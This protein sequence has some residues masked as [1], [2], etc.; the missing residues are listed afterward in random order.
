MAFKLFLVLSISVYRKEAL[1][2]VLVS[3]AS[4]TH[5]AQPT[6]GGVARKTFKIHYYALH[7]FTEI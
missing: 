4:P 1:V 6:A 5:S 2:S 7:V 3:V